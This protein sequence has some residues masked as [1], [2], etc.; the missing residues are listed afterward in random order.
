MYN[1][2]ELEMLSKTWAIHVSSEDQGA[3]ADKI[4]QAT[5]Y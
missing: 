5:M 4:I 1:F 2:T 3:S